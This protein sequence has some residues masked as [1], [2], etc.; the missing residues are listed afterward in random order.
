MNAPTPTTTNLEILPS[1]DLSDL[2]FDISDR[3]IDQDLSHAKELAEHFRAD[4]AG[5]LQDLNPETLLEALKKLE[6]LLE[7]A[8]K[9]LIY[10][11]LI[12]SAD[13]TQPAH[14][15]LL[16]RLEESCT[17]IHQK[18]T[19]FELEWNDLP[20]DQAQ[21]FYDSTVLAH[22]RHYLIASRKF[23]PYQLSEKEEVLLQSLNLVGQ[24]AW[25]RLFD[26]VLSKAIFEVDLP[27]GKKTMSEEEVLALL[28][29]PERKTR[30][31]ASEALTHGLKAQSHLLTYI[32]N[33]IT[34]E[35]A[36][37]DKIRKM[38]HPMKL[39]NLSNE[40][41]DQT[42]AALM[43]ACETKRPLVERF[44][45][46]KTKLLG[47]DKLYD[48]DRYAPIPLTT[49]KNW[50]W[51]EAEAFVGA[52]YAYFDPQ[53]GEIV[54]QFFDKSWID[55]DIRPGKRPGAF[56]ASTVPSAH[57]YILLNFTGNTRDVSTLA[58]ELGHGIHQYLSRQVGYLQTD[59]PLTTAETA[60]V[61]GEMLIFD[62]LLEESNDE[63]KLSLL[64]TKVDEIFATVYRQICLTRFE[65]KLHLTRR[66]EGELENSRINQLWLDANKDLYGD[67]IELTPNYG[68]WWSYIGHFIHSPFYCYA[69]AFGLLLSITLYQSYK[70]RGKSFKEQYLRIL[71]AG[72]SIDPVSLIKIAEIDI[73]K[74]DF[75]L[76]GFDLVEY[77]IQQ[78]ETLAQ[79]LGLNH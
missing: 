10:A 67:S 58:H 71:S 32:F 18:V 54:K 72:G 29:S 3:Q 28:Y 9:P 76:K 34:Q 57:P 12:H 48:Y 75:W 36:L 21:K 20:E 46:L 74:S 59:T 17:E 52:A 13:S 56:S 11:H 37:K 63:E 55:A 7:L 68:W 69:Y 25:S 16:S 50:S 49:S 14:G 42:V 77:M 44:Y 73:S 33:I 30:Q 31:S 19:F 41:D 6:S 45:R 22:Y 27:E 15:A 8:D 39:R 47:L 4:Y 5:K 43:S 62:R 1:W 65:E 61:F 53:T 66:A 51:Q 40:I 24:S 79:K 60:S 23:K 38:P 78:A 35:K 2:Y 26:E 70:E 64:V